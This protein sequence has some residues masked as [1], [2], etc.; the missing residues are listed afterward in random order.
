MKCWGGGSGHCRRRSLRVRFAIPA[1]TSTNRCHRRSAARTPPRRVHSA[2]MHDGTNQA[3]RLLDQ[4]PFLLTAQHLATTKSCS[5][6]H[7]PMA[8]LSQLP[9]STAGRTRRHRRRGRVGRA[10]PGGHIRM[11]ASGARPRR[12]GAGRTGPPAAPRTAARATAA[13]GA[14]ASIASTA[15]GRPR[16]AGHARAIRR[17]LCRAAAATSG[18]ASSTTATAGRHATGHAAL[19]SG[20]TRPCR[21]GAGGTRFI[22]LHGG[23]TAG[24]RYIARPDP[25][26]RASG[27]T[28]PG[29][30]T[31]D[32]ADRTGGESRSTIATARSLVA[33][34]SCAPPARTYSTPLPWRPSARHIIRSRHPRSG[35]GCCGC[36]FGLRK[37]VAGRGSRRPG[38]Y[39]GVAPNSTRGF[40]PGPHQG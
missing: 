2:Q 24:G 35:A 34:N 18:R 27:F 38:S 23:A 21:C 17:Q 31:D 29:C 13:G 8:T 14:S 20:G 11:P 36:T 15:P 7:E 10:D 39:R 3:P 5:S 19:P 28:P 16:R 22:C 6:G 40:A 4:Q 32:G 33:C 25:G 1:C 26:R 37:P 9:A 12:A 30:G